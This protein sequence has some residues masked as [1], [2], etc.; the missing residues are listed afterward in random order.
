MELSKEMIA[1]FDNL[2]RE[3]QVEVVS[4][5]IRRTKKVKA[6]LRCPPTAEQVLSVMKTLENLNLDDIKPY[7]EGRWVKFCFPSQEIRNK[8]LLLNTF[9]VGGE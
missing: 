8:V 3:E 6:Y 2:G 5:L 7:R 1:W 4:L 9:C